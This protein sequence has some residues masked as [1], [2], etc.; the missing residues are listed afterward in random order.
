M[1]TGATVAAHTPGPWRE[2][3]LLFPSVHDGD[4]R[5]VANCLVPFRTREECMANARIVSA[6]PRLLAALKA[7]VASYDGL[8]DGLTSPVVLDKLA[9]ADAAIA[10]AEGRCAAPADAG[11]RTVEDRARDGKN[12]AEDV[13]DA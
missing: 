6:A 9:A 2:D 12:D 7:M 4:G 3:I 13:L 1:S 8:R 11:P 10:K 5:L